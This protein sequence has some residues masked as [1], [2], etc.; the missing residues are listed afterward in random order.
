MRCGGAGPLHRTPSGG[1]DGSLPA[2]VQHRNA[3]I[4]IQREQQPS[5]IRH[6]K[7]ACGFVFVKEPLCRRN[8]E[9]YHQNQYDY[10]RGE[11]LKAEEDYRPDE[12][13]KQPVIEKPRRIAQFEVGVLHI[14]I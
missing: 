7:P 12:V 14:Q 5:D 8:R 2:S 11:H 6:H 4:E 1:R 9:D 10:S 13:Q 3:D